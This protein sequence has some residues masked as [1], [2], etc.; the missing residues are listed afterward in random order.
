MI[1]GARAPILGG[2]DAALTR[3]G[4]DVGGSGARVA[5]VAWDDDALLFSGPVQ[6]FVWDDGFLPVPL[7]E[8][9]AHPEQV[10]AEEEVVGAQRV[11]RLAQMVADCAQGR[12][13]T[14]DVAAP[15]LQTEDGAGILAW[16]NGPRRSTLLADLGRALEAAGVKLASPSLKFRSDAVA[17]ALGELHARGGALRGITNGLCICGG[18]GVGEALLV[19]GRCIGLDELE[20]P[21]ARAWE[22]SGG[23]GLSLEDRVAP[24]RMLRAWRDEGGEGT[25]ESAAGAGGDAAP[26]AAAAACAAREACDA[27]D[28]GIVALLARARTWFLGRDLILERVVLSQRLGVLMAR[29]PERL[30]R[31]AARSGGVEVI[32]SELRGAP[33]IGATV[34]LEESAP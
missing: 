33:V 30:A 1:H 12:W 28:D 24:G 6:E 2:M 13:C 27:R 7:K 23:G 3:I 32:A 15:G 20:P 19:G 10:R 4:I 17:C 18:S 16:R 26:S 31:I 21:L 22:L 34:F 8:Q 25:P 29:S 14:V 5:S 9:L 11:L